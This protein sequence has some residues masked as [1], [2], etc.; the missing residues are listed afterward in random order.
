MFAS[1]ATRTGV[2]LPSPPVY[3]RSGSGERKLS[4]RNFSEGGPR[5]TLPHQRSE[6]RLRMPVPQNAGSAAKSVRCHAGCHAV[7]LRRRTFHSSI[8]VCLKDYGLASQQMHRFFYVYIL[9][10]KSDENI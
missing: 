9:V 3:A 10:S 5:F 2:Q 7:A 6:L 4:R 8:S 1:K